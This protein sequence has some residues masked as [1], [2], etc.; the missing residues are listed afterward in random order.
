MKKME[1]MLYFSNSVLQKL[2]IDDADRKFVNCNFYT[3]CF[4]FHLNLINLHIHIYKYIYI[5]LH[6]FRENKIEICVII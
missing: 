5:K 6:I 3:Q 2:Y 4:A 1:K